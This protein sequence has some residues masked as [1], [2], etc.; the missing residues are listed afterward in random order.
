M[1]LFSWNEDLSVNIDSIDEQHKKLIVM[2]ND[3]YNN[4]S[5]RSSKENIS[6]LIAA[7]KKYTL[8]H[9]SYE[10]KYMK[11]F[12]YPDYEEHKKEHDS[13]VT[14]VSEI[15]K[16]FLEGK[17]FV[18]L[19]ATVFIKDWLKDHIQGADMKYSDFFIKNGI[20]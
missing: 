12:G 13:F 6:I 1:S 15:E 19:E 20:K 14:R 5:T 17:H 10:E 9:F 18:S 4:V 8:E 16:M 3:F 2:I 7:M 11:Q